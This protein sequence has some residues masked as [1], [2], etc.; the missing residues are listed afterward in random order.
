MPPSESITAITVAMKVLPV[1]TYIIH[2]LPHSCRKLPHHSLDSRHMW[3]SE[4]RS[5]QPPS[6]SLLMRHVSN[7]VAGVLTQGRDD[8]KPQGLFSGFLRPCVFAPL[9]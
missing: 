7:L 9:C 2:S 8:A 5:K 6:A 4:C 3:Q 1:C